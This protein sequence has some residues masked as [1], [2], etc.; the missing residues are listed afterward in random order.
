MKRSDIIKLIL[1]G[2]IWGSSY[3]LVKL[4][5]PVTGAFFTT[6]ARITISAVMLYAITLMKQQSTEV[7]S[8]FIKYTVTGL[9]NMIIPYISVTYAARFI[10]TGT[11]AIIN[12][13]TPLFTLLLAFTVLKE[14]V[15]ARKI[16]GIT[17]G[18]TGIVILFG[19]NDEQKL[20]GFTAGFL[21][22]VLAAL[23]YASA[24][25]Y[26]RI[27][28]KNTTPLQIVTGQMLM[29]SCILLPFNVT[30]ISQIVI[31]P[32]V[33]AILL[34]LALLSTTL[35][36]ILYFQ[37]LK[38][39]GAVNAS[40]VTFLI[41]LFSFLWSS[42]FLEEKYSVNTFL[43]MFITLSGLFIIVQPFQQLKPVRPT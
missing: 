27:N 33:I 4:A 41:P 25:I 26:S 3:L 40:L 39:A 28:F 9:L 12:A 19:W 5:V 10:T 8:N 23:S 22:S 36:Y 6:A 1:I 43:S 37:V 32:K 31:P 13:T 38:S 34:C 7:K 42:L 35:G 29:S 2:A 21:L 17:L 16:A 14:Q 24:N 20:P 15:T 18:L 11:G 30:T